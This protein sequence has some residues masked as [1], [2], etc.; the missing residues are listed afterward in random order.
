MQE[1]FG[2]LL[3]LLLNLIE[4]TDDLSAQHV[5]R[6]TKGVA[7]M[8]DQIVQ[9][10]KYREQALLWDRETILLSSQFHD[11][12]KIAV[13]DRI[14]QKQGKL[15][16]EEFTRMQIHTSFGL[17]ILEKVE[18]TAGPSDV[19]LHGKRFAISHHEKWDGSGYPRGIAGEEIPLEGRILAIV[20]VY[21]ALCSD[22][23]YKKAFPH[24]QSALII[25]NS[26]GAHFNPELVDVFLLC[27]EE[28]RN[29]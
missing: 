25:R 29:L 21:D 26:S 5:T 4:Y 23:P 13:S 11:M 12:G 14:L 7:I 27:Q 15:T 18:K 17:E 2:T 9:G 8:Y 20:D 6:T 16:D 19:L 28:F 3:S 10:G 22:R 24:D 1:P